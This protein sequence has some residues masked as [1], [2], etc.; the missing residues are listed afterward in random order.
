MAGHP[1]RANCRTMQRTRPKEMQQA[2]P[3]CEPPAVR[4]TR[5]LPMLAVSILASHRPYVVRQLNDVLFVESLFERLPD[6]VFSVK[7]TEGR[8][9]AIS[10]GCVARCQLRNKHEAIGCTAY[11]LFPSHMA[12]R[13]CAQDAL[14]FAASRPIV[15]SLD[16]TLYNDGGAGWCVSNKQPIQDAEGRLLGLVCISKDLTELSREGLL[17]A[18]FARTIDYIQANYARHLTLQ[19]LADIAGLSIAQLDRRMKWV[20]QVST[21]EFV[22]RTRLEAAL[23]A[24]RVSSAPIADIAVDTGFFDQSALHKQ[25]KQATGLSP[26]QLRLMQGREHVG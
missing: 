13:Y 21:G 12:Q 4:H 19:E 2:R 9:L 20:F 1:A 25:C 14:V 7:D 3:R 24:I 17:D 26:R 15:D 22:R 11:D 5:E 23:H 18:G 8:Y 10:N 16:L 6:V